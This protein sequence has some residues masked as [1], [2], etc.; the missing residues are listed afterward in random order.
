MKQECK[1]EVGGREDNYLCCLWSFKHGLRTCP[2]I[3]PHRN[4]MWN[5]FLYAGIFGLYLVCNCFCHWWIH[6]LLIYLIFSSF[7]YVSLSCYWLSPFYL[8][9][10]GF[11][12]YLFFKFLPSTF[13]N[14]FMFSVLCLLTRWLYLFAVHTCLLPVSHHKGLAQAF[15]E[16][17]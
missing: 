10:W 3:L 1:D 5:L 8:P 4:D 11:F 9:L 7:V 14:L 13:K 6:C 2:W 17:L 16:V 15:I 12:I